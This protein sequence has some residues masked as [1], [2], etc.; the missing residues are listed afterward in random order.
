[1]QLQKEKVRAIRDTPVPQNTQKLKA[2]RGLMNYYSKF[3]NNL[4]QRLAPLY[5]LLNKNVKWQW[6]KL[7][8]DAFDKAKSLLTSKYLLIHFNPSVP[9]RL[10]G[11]ASADGVGAVLSHVFDNGVENPIAFTSRSLKPTEKKCSQLD[12]ET[13]SLVFG[14]HKF[15]KYLYGLHFEIV[16]DHKPLLGL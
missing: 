11:D 7:Q 3:I 4:S 12:R 13:L 8:Q 2:F 1:M 15:H 9:L 6:G 16:T 14:V 5:A 10:T